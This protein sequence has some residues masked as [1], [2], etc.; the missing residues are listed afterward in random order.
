[1]SRR[2]YKHCE[3]DLQGRAKNTAWTIMFLPCVDVGERRQGV[4][5]WEGKV[6]DTANNAHHEAGLRADSLQVAAGKLLDC[7]E[8]QLGVKICQGFNHALVHVLVT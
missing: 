3:R 6:T 7:F 8:A 5:V 2:P 4:F 1:M